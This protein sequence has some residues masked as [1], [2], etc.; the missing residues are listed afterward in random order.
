MNMESVI[1]TLCVFVGC[2]TWFCVVCYVVIQLGLLT[3]LAIVVVLFVSLLSIVAGIAGQ[4]ID[5]GDSH[6]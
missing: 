1:R 3:C 4:G 5:I 6:D 2:L